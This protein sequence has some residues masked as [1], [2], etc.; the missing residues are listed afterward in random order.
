MW[1]ASATLLRKHDRRWCR[2]SRRASR[3]SRPLA[4][5]LSPDR[6]EIRFTAN[7]ATR[8]K[9]KLAQDLLRHSVPT[10]DPAEIFDRALTALIEQVARRKLAIV[11]APQRTAR[12]TTAGSRH[13][14]SGVK[15]AVWRRDG[16]RCAFVGGN[17]HRCGERAFL[18]FHHVEPHAVGGQAT[19]ENIA[20]RCRAHNAHESEL[21][22][23]TG[24]TGD[25][26]GIVNDRPNGSF[27]GV[28]TRF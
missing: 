7:A 16:G 9:L 23:G 21:F 28:F 5:P 14:P 27:P 18:E 10:G 26:S 3:K 8:D 4:T 22:Y 12:N 17:G 24:R 2:R 13:I 20:L 1:H 6:Y 25:G 19:V 11:R 15:R